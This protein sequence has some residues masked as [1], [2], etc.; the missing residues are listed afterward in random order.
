MRLSPAY[1]TQRVNHHGYGRVVINV[2]KRLGLPLCA[3]YAFTTTTKKLADPIGWL[4]RR[5]VDFIADSPWRDAMPENTAWRAFAPAEIPGSTE[6]AAACRSF[7]HGI[8]TR[9]ARFVG[10]TAY[11]DLLSPLGPQSLD[12]N[13]IPSALDTIPGLLDFALSRPL[14]DAATAYLGEIPVLGGI[15]FYASIPNDRLEGS[16]IY[17]CDQGD[18]RLFKALL[19]VGDVDSDTGPFTFVPADKTGQVKRALGYRRGRLDD[20]ALFS[21]VRPSDQ[22]VFTGQAGSVLFCD[23]ARCL[24]YGS[25]GNRKTR[26]L[27][28]VL[29]LSR[30]HRI[31]GRW[32]LAE[33]AF[34]RR[35]YGGDRLARL[36]LGHHAA[37]A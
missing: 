8:E 18:P 9:V 34:D 28:E 15:T 20:A 22:V 7:F 14:V 21:V 32:Q 13:R 29:Y 16:Q 17:H 3:A 33:Q 2:A 35:R 26:L 30:Y 31:E 23:T 25:R 19:A 1:L 10:E 11:V 36:L 4:A 27:L 12:S 6:L 24:H 5:R 37:N